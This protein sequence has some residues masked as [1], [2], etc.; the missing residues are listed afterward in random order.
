MQ[1]EVNM[2]ENKK[3]LNSIDW[4]FGT[5]VGAIIV[6][7]L[8]STPL[9]VSGYLLAGAIVWIIGCL[10]GGAVAFGIQMVVA[11]ANGQIDKF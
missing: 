2:E 4:F 11:Q 6:A 1:T 9:F 3:K 5:I 8:L 7:I 10:L